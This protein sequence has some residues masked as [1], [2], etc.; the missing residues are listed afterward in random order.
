MQKLVFLIAFIVACHSFSYAQQVIKPEE[1]LQYMGDSVTVCGKIFGG[2]FL[3]SAKN[4][5]TFL[6]MGATFP[7]Q[8]LTIVI[9]G[10]TRKLFSYTPEEK[11]KNK[12]VCITGR[13][14]QFNSKPQIVIYNVTQLREE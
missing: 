9:W 1:A 7:D 13:I 4:Q 14:G 12:I 2:K 11:L 5:P 3:E 10:D 8:L 6:N